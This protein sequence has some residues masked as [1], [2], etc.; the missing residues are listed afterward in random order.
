M[1]GDNVLTMAKSMRI[2]KIM[3]F[4]FGIHMAM[5]IFMAEYIRKGDVP[6]AQELYLGYMIV[7]IGLVASFFFFRAKLTAPE[8]ALQQDPQDR[9]ALGQRQKFHVF[10]L[11]ISEALVLFGFVVRFMGESVGHSIPFY[12]AGSIMLLLSTPRKLD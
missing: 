8:S 2:L 6:V 5:V 4:A 9:V 7:S 3:Q 11:A 1:N 12:M 10:L